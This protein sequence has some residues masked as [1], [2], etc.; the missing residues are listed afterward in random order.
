LAE[1]FEQGEWPAVA[2]VQ[3]VGDG[4]AEVRQDTGRA[5]H[6]SRLTSAGSAGS[7]A[8]VRFGICSGAALDA[9]AEFLV[10]AEGPAG[11]NVPLFRVFSGDGSRLVSLYRQNAAGDRLYIQVGDEYAQTFGRLPLGTWAIVSLHVSYP[12]GRVRNI[13]VIV[14]GRLVYSATR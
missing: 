1:D 10:E 14:D 11:A 13:E 5:T 12:E 9:T 4:I 8:Y 6:V 3:T 2:T 7:F